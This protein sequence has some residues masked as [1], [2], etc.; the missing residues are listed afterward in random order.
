MTNP[1]RTNPAKGTIV[2]NCTFRPLEKWPRKNTPFG[3][4]RC[5]SHFKATFASTLDLLE[6]ELNHLRAKDIVVQ[7]ETT[8]DEI[9]NDGWPRSDAR[10][11]GPRVSISFTSTHGPLAYYCD[12]CHHWQ[13]NLRCIAL[14]LERLRMAELYGVTKRGEQYQGFKA[15]PGAIEVGPAMTLEEAARVVANGAGHPDRWHLMIASVDA[16]KTMFRAGCHLLHADAGDRPEQWVQF[17]RASEML[18][19]H[20]GIA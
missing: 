9:R 2:I 12:D 16:F 13:H 18:K 4:R 7:I 5:T 11:S 3:D 20:Y 8:L 1:T 19:H 15:L 14:T 10:V 17:Q 6:K